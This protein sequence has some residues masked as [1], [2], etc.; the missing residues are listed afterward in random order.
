MDDGT[1]TS[2]GSGFL[3]TGEHT[4]EGTPYSLPSVTISENTD[5]ATYITSWNMA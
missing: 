4:Y 2:S 1:V 3:V 5:P